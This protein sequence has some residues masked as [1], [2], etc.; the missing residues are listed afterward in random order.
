[1][2]ESLTYHNFQ[3][4]EVYEL[5]LDPFATTIVGPSDRGKTALL[6]G[7]KWLCVNKPKGDAFITHG[8]TTCK[9]TLTLDEGQRIVRSKGEANIY[10]L[11]KE[12]L[13]LEQGG[14]VP[15]PISDLLNLSVELSFQNQLDGPFLLSKSPGDVAK[16]L[17]GVVNL[18]S[19]DRVLASLAKQ[20]RTHKASVEVS[21]ERLESAEK[22]A[23][24]LAWVVQANEDY[25]E[26]EKVQTKYDKTHKI[27]ASGALLVES[28]LRLDLSCQTL[29]KAILDG[30]KLR[31]LQERLEKLAAKVAKLE[32]YLEEIERRGKEITDLKQQLSGLEK[33]L[34][35]KLDGRCPVCKQDWSS[36]HRGSDLNEE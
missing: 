31:I 17:N 27:L 16:A 33:D 19:I 20:T 29:S 32:T 5:L 4:Y 36:H 26:L 35:E 28:A 21:E 23:D 13:Q 2:L 34:E 25:A 30:E 9:V 8:E 24:S 6:R 14:A 18:D 22:R 3:C 1:M 12:K 11:G 10:R 15:T 7:L